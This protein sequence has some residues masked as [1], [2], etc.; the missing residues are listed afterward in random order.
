MGMAIALAAGAA[1]AQSLPPFGSTPPPPPRT[2]SA[3]AAEQ[4]RAGTCV[5]LASYLPATTSFYIQVS[6]L[7]RLIDRLRGNPAVTRFLAVP[8]VAELVAEIRR[9]HTGALADPEVGPWLRLVEAGVGEQISVGVPPESF[10]HVDDLVRALVLDAVLRGLLNPETTAAHSDGAAAI[11]RLRQSFTEEVKRLQLPGFT[12]GLRVTD[13]KVTASLLER[14]VPALWE[15]LERELAGTMGRTVGPP[16]LAYLRV[17]SHGVR[18]HRFEVSPGRLLGFGAVETTHR[19]EPTAD[20]TAQVDRAVGALRYRLDLAVVGSHLVMAAN[21]DM[22]VPEPVPRTPNPSPFRVNSPPAAYGGRVGEG[23]KLS[24]RLA[25][26]HPGCRESGEPLLLSYVD[27]TRVR[28]RPR[29]TGLLRELAGASVLAVL[30]AP[31]VVAEQLDRVASRLDALAVAGSDGAATFFRVNPGIEVMTTYWRAKGMAS[32]VPG[33]LSIPRRVPDDASGYVATRKDLQAIFMGGAAAP[34]GAP[35]PWQPGK[36]ATAG[37][38][39]KLPDSW[40]GLLGLLAGTA[41]SEA[42]AVLGAARDL[43]TRLQAASPRGVGIVIPPVAFVYVC[44]EPALIARALQLGW[45]AAAPGVAELAPATPA[46]GAAEYFELRLA[47][48]SW[49]GPAPHVAAGSGMVVASTSTELTRKIFAASAGRLASIETQGL[50][51]ALAGMRAAQASEVVFLDGKRGVALVQRLLEDS[52]APRRGDRGSVLWGFVDLLGTVEA[53]TSITTATG[54]ATEE[55]KLV[56]SFADAA[57]R[58]AA[59]LRER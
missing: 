10:D 22:T 50:H 20:F 19:R 4:T 13:P 26:R 29:T 3:P 27:A 39:E 15:D 11:G 59:T 9:E 58:G 56:I 21:A 12:M 53:V 37:R 42:G 30:G 7:S 23:G 48:A 45:A 2:M 43:T 54:G 1:A 5:G 57:P 31:P 24:E 16:P 28:R 36:P 47:G 40:T 34:A 18:V 25:S 52:G 44:T 51:R 32:A 41:C 33:T 6:G 49:S 38:A 8:D 46:S 35:Q 55:S 17:T 14:L